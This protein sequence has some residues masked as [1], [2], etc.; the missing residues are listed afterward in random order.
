MWVLAWLVDLKFNKVKL[1]VIILQFFFSFN[2]QQTHFF[3]FKE[4]ADHFSV[5]SGC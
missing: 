3:L 4:N 1:F 2:T 5:L